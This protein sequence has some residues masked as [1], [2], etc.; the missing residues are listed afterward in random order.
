MTILDVSPLL[1]APF[2]DVINLL[3]RFGVSPEKRV[4]LR[5]SGVLNPS[6]DC[7]AVRHHNN[8]VVSDGIW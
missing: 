4:E 6:L 2:V 8:I 3:L 5:T 1:N 7:R